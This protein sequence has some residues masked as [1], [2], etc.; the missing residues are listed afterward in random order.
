M[1]FHPDEHLRMTIISA[2]AENEKTA[3]LNL[4]V[5]VVNGVAHLGGSAPTF[6]QWELAQGI[7]AQI[8]GIRGVVNRIEAPNAPA[9]GRI[10]HLDLSSQE[11]S[12]D[13]I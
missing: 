10:I 1:D 3:T 9:P 5:G 8:Q 12:P 2:L 6:T 13:G 11:P 7:A 4:R